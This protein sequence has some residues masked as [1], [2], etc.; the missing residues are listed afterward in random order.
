[1][2]VKNFNILFLMVLFFAY[3]C[4][5]L[6]TLSGKG[7][8][9]NLKTDQLSQEDQ[10]LVLDSKSYQNFVLKNPEKSMR[11]HALKSISEFFKLFII[12]GACVN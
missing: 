10:K 11:E 5:I 2:R 1:M 3:S 12:F 6:P 9:Y 7:N 8:I 4:K